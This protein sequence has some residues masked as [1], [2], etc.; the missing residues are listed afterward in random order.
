MEFV[1]F[2]CISSQ[3]PVM[4]SV[5]PSPDVDGSASFAR[6]LQQ[7]VDE[8]RVLELLEASASVASQKSAPRN[9]MA[10]YF[11]AI[12][13]VRVVGPASRLTPEIMGR[14]VQLVGELL[15]QV[16]PDRQLGTLKSHALPDYPGA[17]CHG[18][19]ILHVIAYSTV[20]NPVL[21][22]GFLT[23][24]RK[25]G[26]MTRKAL[27]SAE[28][29]SGAL[30]LHVAAEANNIA[31]VRMLINDNNCK[32]TQ[33]DALGRSAA[34]IASTA[35][36]AELANFIQEKEN[37]QIRKN[38]M[39]DAAMDVV[40][41]R[42]VDPRIMEQ[43]DTVD[44]T[45]EV[46]T[47]PE[48]VTPTVEQVMLAA[49]LPKQPIP[50]PR[51]LLPTVSSI[52]AMENEKAAEKQVDIDELKAFMISLC[53]QVPQGRLFASVWT[54]FTIRLGIT[55]VEQFKKVLTGMPETAQRFPQFFR[56]GIHKDSSF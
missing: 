18:L 14:A 10:K 52:S 34:D 33:M 1:S 17:D 41:N 53:E 54:D 42:V 35:G 6:Y 11:L 15:N 43:E 3:T 9:P 45:P 22:T 23:A 20:S 40:D 25:A 16:F 32:Y 27:K 21:A 7:C 36:H 44:T 24:C 5:A 55:Q 51:A 46:I 31:M 37:D 28:I 38:V 29:S 8:E 49:E 26:I 13:I 56:K 19:N 30:P 47:P 48:V 2:F 50:P 39:R 4:T 12:D